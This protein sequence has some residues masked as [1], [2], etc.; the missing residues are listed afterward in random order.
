MARHCSLCNDVGHKRDDCPDLAE[1]RAK[2]SD[3]FEDRSETRGPGSAYNRALEDETVREILRLKIEEN[4][5]PKEIAEITGVSSASVIRYLSKNGV[6]L[7]PIV[8]KAEPPMS[9]TM[10]E[11][12]K[13]SKTWEMGGNTYEIAQK[14][15][16]SLGEVNAA[17]VASSY[18]Y[19]LRHR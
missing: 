18:D 5:L 10:F 4:L 9:R 6:P 8:K 12:V 14:L 3:A 17:W 19:Y 13:Q 15:G 1:I 7:R 16:T 2:H 11:K